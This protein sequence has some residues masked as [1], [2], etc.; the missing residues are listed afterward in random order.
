MVGIEKQAQEEPMLIMAVLQRLALDP[1][2]QIVLRQ[3]GGPM[4]GADLEKIRRGVFGMSQEELGEKWG[5][6]RNYI[7]RMEKKKDVEVEAKICDAYRGL[8][9]RY[10][11]GSM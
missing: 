6:S 4:T 3:F 11:L 9:L 1:T 8:M 10:F 5:V 2:Y 7:M